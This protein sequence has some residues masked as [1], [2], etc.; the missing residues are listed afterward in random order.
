MQLFT[1]DMLV[2]W[3]KA[4]IK[5]TKISRYSLWW[6]R[7]YECEG[8]YAYTN[9]PEVNSMY[10]MPSASDESL[11]IGAALHYY[12]NNFNKDFLKNNGSMTDLYLGEPIYHKDLKATLNKIKKN[13]NY[14]IKENYDFDNTISNILHKG[15]PISICNGRTEWGARALCNRS[16]IAKSRFKDIVEKIN[17]QIKM[18][19]FWMPFAP[20]IL[21]TKYKSCIE[22]K[23]NIK[24]MFMT[25]HYQPKKKHKIN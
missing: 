22:D 10:V 25:L 9:L 8:K 12:N 11:S 2:K 16:I 15:E 23:K 20:T 4:A 14:I 6:R 24:P 3:V 5:K 17:S 18:R 7:I 19:D 21:D 13:T 1:E